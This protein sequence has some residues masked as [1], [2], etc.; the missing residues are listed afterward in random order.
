MIDGVSCQ[1]DLIQPAHYSRDGKPVAPQTHR[2]QALQF[3]GKPIDDASR[4]AVVTNNYRAAGG[5]SFPGLDGKR[6]FM[7]APDENRAALIQV[8]RSNGG[9]GDSTKRSIHP[10]AD[11][12][13]RMLPVAGIKLRFAPVAGAI[14]HLPRYPQIELI[15]DNGDGSALIESTPQLPGRL[16]IDGWGR[17]P[18]S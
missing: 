17:F 16:R 5:G 15:K 7:D 10:S 13:W 12:D 1:I 3:Q 6:I 18:G 2:I 4:F 11:S 9:T 14:A 8:L